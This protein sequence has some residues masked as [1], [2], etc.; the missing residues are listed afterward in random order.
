LGTDGPDIELAAAAVSL[1]APYLTEA[2]KEAAKTVG[3]E[4]AK[5]G[6]RLLS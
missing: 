3:K 5:T 6:V 2:G 4:T 1:L